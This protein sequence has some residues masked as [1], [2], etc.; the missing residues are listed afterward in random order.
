M[1]ICLVTGGA[2]FIGSHLVEA[3][4]RHGHTV[5]V[6]DNFS[7]GDPANLEPVREQVRVF[8]GDITD[9]TT[10][11][12]AV[13]GVEVV[14][15]QAALASVPRSIADPLAT[16]RACATG[17]LH[18]LQ[19]AKEAGVRRVVYA[20]SSSAYGASTR[21]PKCE[22]DPTLPLSPY[23]V[24]KL[25]GE[26]YCAAFSGVYGLETVRLR[27]FNVFGP[28][29]SPQSQYAAV[30]PKFIEAM[31]AGRSPV[32]HGDGEQSRDFTFVADVVRANLL[33]A[34]APGVSGNVYNIACGCRTSLLEL[35]MFLNTLLGSDIKPV[36]TE[37][38]PGDVR[39][40][41]ASIERACQDLGYEP[42][43]DIVTGLRH[44]LEWWRQRNRTPQSKRRSVA[45]A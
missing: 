35:V 40:S 15:H 23:A 32:L 5:R 45:I 33:A 27:Y 3:L 20:A 26:Q 14:F 17:T 25:A 38:R 42:T 34:E 6:L 43:T 10:V 24:A 30:I 44:C 2:G 12:A 18:I 37:A 29:Q 36:H 11:Q 8:D 7:T 9:L 4:L 41:Q 22:S 21:L 28:R 16:H 1:A 13:Q 39:H 31:T 19:A